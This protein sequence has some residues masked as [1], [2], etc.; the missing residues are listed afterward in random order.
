MIKQNIENNLQNQEWT[1]RPTLN[2]VSHQLG[3]SD[4]RFDIRL[5]ED[6]ENSR[7]EMLGR[8]ELEGESTGLRE[9]L[10]Q[11]QNSLRNNEE[12][13]IGLKK[14]QISWLEI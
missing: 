8:G 14:V 1:F 6:F 5:Y 10:K 4:S 7:L 11:Y 13:E 9:K 12:K 2:P 3:Y